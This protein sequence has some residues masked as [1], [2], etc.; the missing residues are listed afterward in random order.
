MNKLEFEQTVLL[1]D[2]DN[3][4]YLPSAGIL[5]QIGQR[6]KRYVANS[7]NLS[8]EQATELCFGYYHRYGGTL[9]GLQQH[10]PEVDLDDF[11]VYAHNVDTSLL[12]PQPQLA[13]AL[14]GLQNR[15]YIFTNSALPYAKRLLEKME[16]QN[17]FDG[18]FSVE[19]TDFKMKPDAIA[20][21]RICRKFDVDPNKAMMFDDQPA[22]LETAASMGMKTV[23]VNRSDI[24]APTTTYATSELTQFLIGL[25]SAS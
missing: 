6:M 19:D 11:S 13:T 21:E 18:I 8:F 22:N 20:Y 7:L 4:L 1:F 16:L 10:H 12:H 23:L 24:T 15:K 9:R 14:N 25:K 3:T 17:C 2:L 5:D